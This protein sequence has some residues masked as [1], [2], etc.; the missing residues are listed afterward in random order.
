LGRARRQGGR[1]LEGNVIISKGDLDKLE[2]EL[3]ELRA[4]NGRL[5]AA[6][7]LAEERGAWILD[8]L[9]MLQYEVNTSGPIRRARINWVCEQLE[10]SDG[11]AVPDRVR[12]RG[13]RRGEPGRVADL[14]LAGS[15]EER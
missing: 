1:F 5:R 2:Y 10:V 13:D 6:L 15:R 3:H 11:L 12:P 8:G 7:E 4:E 9:K 14:H